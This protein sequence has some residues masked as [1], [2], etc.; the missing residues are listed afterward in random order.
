VAAYVRGLQSH[1][2]LATLKHF[3]GH[4]DTDVDS[5]LGLP[6]IPHPRERLESMELVPFRG[7]IAAGAEAV[8]TSHIELPALEPAPSTPATF[9]AAVATRLLRNDLGF[10][11]LAFTDSM[12][13]AGVTK[14]AE[15]GDAAVRAFMAG[16]D[17]LLDLPDPPA[18]FNALKAAMDKGEITDARL[19]ESVTRILRAKA[20]LGLHKQKQVSL[21]AIAQALGGRANRAVAQ[22]VSERSLTLLKDERT[23]VPLRV[24]GNA[25]I[26]YLS[27]IDYPGQWGI[28]A[29]SRTMAPELRKRWPNV[30]AIELSDETTSSELELLRVSA[31]RYDAV[32]A[33]VIVRAASSSGRMDLAPGVARTLT[34]IARRTRAANKPFVA[35]LF[36]NPYVAI[37]L[38]ELP[39]ILLTYDFYDLAELTAV[40]G[41]AGEIPIGGRL[42][43]SLPG[44]FP[45]GHGL[46]RGAISARD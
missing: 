34:D 46:T 14:L 23:A 4:G 13:M 12:K 45:V 25:S 39:A 40:R 28:A 15:P 27:A 9:S 21:D 18:A 5:H 16:H 24:P 44:L 38:P 2:V 19:T 35:V 31:D 29:P 8:M 1:H 33:S 26:L 43:V 41:L 11:G 22:I 36:G 20:R 37:G 42:P 7:G 32:V 10:T 30:T 3:P 6:V 17:M